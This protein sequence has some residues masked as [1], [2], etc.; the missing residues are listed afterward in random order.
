MKIG[1][2]GG[3]ISGLAS[4]WF[5]EEMH[6]VI[7]F[8]RQDRLGG[9]ANTVLVSTSYGDVPIET[10]FEF[11]NSTM[12][13]HFTRLLSLLEVPTTSY[14]FNYTFSSEKTDTIFILP[15]WRSGKIFWDMLGINKLNLVLELKYIIGKC[16]QFV[17]K[18][19]KNTTIE[20][21]L[22]QCNV[23]ESFKND[24]FIPL[25]CAGWGISP[26][27][28]RTFAAYNLLSWMVNNKVMGL[29]DCTWDEIPTGMSSYVD[30]L[31]AQIKRAKLKTS[32]TIQN[33]TYDGKQ[34]T[35]QE[36]DGSHNT[37]DHLIVA[38]NAQE[39]HALLRNIP[40]LHN[41][42]A[43]LNQIEY[44]DATIAIHG[45]ERFM[46]KNKKHWSVANV[47]YNSKNSILTTHKPWHSQTLLLRSWL[48]TGFPHPE[49]LYATVDYRHAQVTPTYFH[50]QQH[51]S[52]L[53][54][55]HNVWIAGLYTHDIDS[56]ESA[57]TSAIKIAGRLA[58][59]SRRYADIMKK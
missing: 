35:V 19:D 11:F 33:I 10:G 44:I 23:T 28:F 17:Q 43:L 50:V 15:P 9:H 47:W 20:Q 16:E 12:F 7:L 14:P 31:T 5:L 4:A 41:R 42:R 18:K 39:A 53:Q 24:F 2:I 3:G 29:Q 37:F 57:L 22:D 38:T 27:K 6:D 34:Y 8:E 58:P 26:E 21:F 25:F 32:V 55:E 49:P 1:I 30:A 52:A 40:Q 56:H 13:P 48:M 46:P 54:G 51:L 45:D 59:E 36:K